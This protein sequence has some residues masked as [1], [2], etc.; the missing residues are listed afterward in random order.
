MAR[1]ITALVFIIGMLLLVSIGFCEELPRPNYDNSVIFSVTYSLGQSSSEIDYIKSLFGNGIYAPLYFTHFAQIDMDWTLDP[2]QADSGIQAFKN[3]VE[4]LITT[5]KTYNVE[6]HFIINYGLARN[7]GAYSVAKEE[8]IR[9]AQWYNDNNLAAADQLSG[10]MNDKVFGTFSRY[11]RKLRIFHEAKIQALFAFLKQKQDDNPDFTLI[12]SGP[13][14]AELNYWRIDDG[15]F[16][17]SDFC[18]YSPFAVLEFRDW[19][20]HTGMYGPGGAYAGDG[21]SSG[22]SRYQDMNGLQNFNS[23]FGTDFT[24]WDLKYYNWSLTDSFEDGALPFTGYSFG[25]Q[26][27]G[28]GPNF[29]EGGFD[30]ARI[31][32]QK[33]VDDFWDLWHSFR[34]FLVAHY[35]KDMAKIARDSGF[36]KKQY[37]TH[38]IPADHLFGTRPN[39]PLIPLLNPRYYTSASPMWTANAFPDTGMA[40]TLYDLK[41]NESLFFR[42]SL[43]AVP[44][45]NVMS[46]NWAALEYN[47]EVHAGSSIP[48]SSVQDMYE[49]MIRL[50]N[51]NVHV[52]SFF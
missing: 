49:Q 33:G 29:I 15:S 48:E 16:L 3:Q 7:V 11:A 25:G 44:N 51:N 22:G 43:Y 38:Q 32:K 13:G 39:D 1:R 8:D 31:M 28:T 6:L 2:S 30:P 18:D 35:V 47:P 42:T 36:P 21:Y 23:D 41:I 17:Q 9:N 46:S 45:I 19:I 12:V 10:V 20:R 37:Y 14:E 24:S 40:I 4:A 34:E 52:I 27:P 26:M 50:Y 5:A